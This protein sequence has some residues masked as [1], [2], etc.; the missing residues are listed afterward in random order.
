MKATANGVILNQAS[1]GAGCAWSGSDHAER[2]GRHNWRGCGLLLHIFARGKIGRCPEADLVE[3]Y[4]QRIGWPLRIT[5]QIGRAS[6]RDRVCQS[7]K[8]SAVAVS[9]Q[10]KQK[11][12]Q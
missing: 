1:T 12:T 2:R 11:H 3:R 4:V 8:S 10:K 5:E 9:L 6:C 7:G